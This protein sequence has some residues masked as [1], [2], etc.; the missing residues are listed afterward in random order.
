MTSP[1]SSSLTT[2]P[3]KFLDNTRPF[4][5][6]EAD[7]LYS[8]VITNYGNKT[9]DILTFISDVASSLKETKGYEKELF[10]GRL[11]KNVNRSRSLTAKVSQKEGQREFD[12]ASAKDWALQS[13][14]LGLEILSKKKGGPTDNEGTVEFVAKYK[15]DGKV[16]EH[17]EVAKFSKNSQ[18]H[19][20]FVDGD[21]HIH[22]EGEGHHHHEKP[23]TL[24]RTEPKVG[25]N[26]PCPCGSGKKF[27]KC[28]G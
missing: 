7:R 28:C 26:D 8:K 9:A 14:W 4:L 20:Q 13:E 17:H 16:L 11:E 12:L 19:W 1:I 21:S 22:K 23:V 2:T 15:K 10:W 6:E 25:R 5:M 24:V 27:K 3:K 18:G